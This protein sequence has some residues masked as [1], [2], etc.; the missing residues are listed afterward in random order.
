MKNHKLWYN[1]IMMQG[2]IGITRHY[3]SNPKVDLKKLRPMILKRIENRAKDYPVKAM[4]PV[5]NDVLQSRSLLIQGVAT[6]LQVIPI[7][8]CKYSLSI[9][10]LQF[11][12]FV[13]FF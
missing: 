4:I 9:S 2:L 3:R 12:C 1:V 10:N 5:A 13:I 6:L 8:S 11:S 7:W